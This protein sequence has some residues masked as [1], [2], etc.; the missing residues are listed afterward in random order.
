MLLRFCRG[1]LGQVVPVD[2]CGRSRSRCRRLGFLSLPLFG[3]WAGRWCRPGRGLV[4]V[5]RQ[6][7]L[8][9]DLFWWWWRTLAM[10]RSFLA[11]RGFRGRLRL[12]SDCRL[13]GWGLLGL[14]RRVLAG[15]GL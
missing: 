6:K 10:L 3:R 1:L 2:L 13:R 5:R 4:L 12:C 11:R 7:A 8:N 14:G 9:R 15:L